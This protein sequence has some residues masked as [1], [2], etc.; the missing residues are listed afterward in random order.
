MPGIK[1]GN[2]GPKFGF[3]SKENGWLTL[4]NVRIPRNQL[5]QRFIKINREGKV[6]LAGDQRILYSTMLKTRMQMISYTRFVL[7]KVLLIAIRYSI[8][9]R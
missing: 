2:L 1:C 4:N 5:L 3:H 6:S 9:R 8:V 7:A